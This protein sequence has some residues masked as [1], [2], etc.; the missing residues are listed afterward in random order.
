MKHALV[1]GGA[2]FIGSHLVDRLLAEGWQV[3]ALDNFDPF[4]PR[5]IKEANLCR[6]AGHPRFRLLCADIRDPSTWAANLPP[7]KPDV[8]VHLAARAGVLP[9]LRDPL[10]YQATNVTGT[11]H[12]LE[13]ARELGVRQFVLASSSS[14]YGINP[15]VP[16]REDAAVMPISPYA[17]TKAST[18]LLA[19]AYR[20]LHGLRIIALRF[21]T[22]IGP[23]QRP[24]LAIHKFARLIVRGE[25]VPFYGD[26]SSSRDYTYID[27]T[28]SGV[29][30][31]MDYTGSEFEIVN[32]GNTHS[33]SLAE[34][35]RCLEDALGVKAK[36]QRL[37][38]QA[39]DVPRTAA[40]IS[41]ARSLLGYEPRT[42]FAAGVRAFAEWL[43]SQ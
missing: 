40:D 30:A 19:H 2:G 18:E 25:P 16:W 42:D 43:R 8:S 6:H 34:M 7:E 4:Y 17:V 33:I 41:K 14:V 1:T 37:P 29:R 23:R 22:V 26:G 38:I 24:D 28:I 15:N 21:F 10:G 12:M 13:L 39:G 5:A 27:D 11:H 36:L 32:L 20:H 3:T 31:A 9:S 35:V